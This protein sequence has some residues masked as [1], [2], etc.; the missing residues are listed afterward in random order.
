M[1]QAA[2]FPPERL[3]QWGNA[4]LDEIALGRSG[5]VAALQSARRKRKMS[6]FNVR[7]RGDLLHQ[8][9]EPVRCCFEQYCRSPASRSSGFDRPDLPESSVSRGHRVMP[10]GLEQRVGCGASATPSDQKGTSTRLRSWPRGE[11]AVRIRRRTCGRSSV[12]CMPASAFG[13]GAFAACAIATVVA[14][15]S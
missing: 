6:N 13:A 8:K 7:H 2:P 1:P 3:V 4:L 10:I 11:Q 15:S 12:S 14:R 9:H 5:A